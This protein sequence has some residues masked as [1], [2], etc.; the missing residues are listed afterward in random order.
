MQIA[1]LSGMKVK[2][3][4]EQSFPVNLSPIA[5]SANGQGT[6]ISNGYLTTT[7]GIRAR[8]TFAGKDRGGRVWKG[9]HYR[10]LGD[11]LVKVSPNGSFSSLGSVGDDGK[12][13]VFASSFDRLAIAS[14][15]RL[16]YYDGATITQVVDADLGSVLS[17][18]WLDSYFVTT[19]GEYLVATELNDPASIDPLKYGSS[20]ADP[21]PIVAVLAL[22]GELYALNRFTIEVFGN[23]GS[24]GFPFQRQRG[25]QIPKGVA[26]P[27]AFAPFLESFAFVGSALNESPSVYVAGSGDASPLSPRALNKAL[28]RLSEVELAAVEVETRQADGLT[29][30]HVHLPSEAWVFHYT[31]SKALGLPV[32]TLLRGQT[33]AWPARHYTLFN[34]QWWCGGEGQLG[35]LDTTLTAT[36]NQPIA[37]E[38]HT[39]VVYNEGRG[40]IVNSLELVV[41]GGKGDATPISMSYSDDGETWSQERVSSNGVRGDRAA[42]PAWRRVGRMAHWRL[43]RFRGYAKSPFAVSRLEADLEALSA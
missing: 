41:Q 26:G 40:A 25:A 18:A 8:S 3:G 7:A 1:I 10:V 29:E 2:D 16:F 42:R 24:A 15:S 11:K 5:E 36:F 6:G 13:V 4:F 31:A 17:V 9:S 32:W 27:H 12:P 35:T 33:G 30:L 23:A 20:E 38:V 21:D 37:F 39:P 14:N 19:D 43:F 34:N 28:S 22:R